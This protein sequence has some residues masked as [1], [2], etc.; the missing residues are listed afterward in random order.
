MIPKIPR[1]IL[2][3]QLG[4]TYAFLILIVCAFLSGV[5]VGFVDTASTYGASDDVESAIYGLA[6]LI[7]LGASIHILYSKRD[8]LFIKK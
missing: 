1:I 6:G 4:A 8:L 2:N 7:A 5:I 3:I